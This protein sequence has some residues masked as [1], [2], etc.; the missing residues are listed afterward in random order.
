MPCKTYCRG[1]PP[2]ERP[3]PHRSGQGEDGRVHRLVRDQPGQRRA[4]PD[5]GRRLRA[6]QLRHRRDHGRAG[7]RHAR[8]R[9]R[10]SSST[11]RSCRSSIRAT[12]S[13]REE[14]SEDPGRQSVFYRTTARRSTRATTTACRPPSSSR[15][16]PHDLAAQRPGPAGGQLQ[17]PRLALQ[18]AA[19]LGRAVPDPARTGR[20]RQADRPRPCRRR[21]R[22]AGRPAA[23]R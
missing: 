18:P 12:T 7:P 16:S 20:R 15:R 22:T 2:Q 10:R 4:G 8:L 14:R 23:P 17:A 11:C 6:D 19:L 21:R 1:R 13:R 9:V 3:R 5:L